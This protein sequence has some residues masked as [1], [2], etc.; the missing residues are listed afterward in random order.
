MLHCFIQMVVLEALRDL[1]LAVAPAIN[2]YSCL[3]K[4]NLPKSESSH[5][6]VKELLAKQGLVTLEFFLHGFIKSTKRF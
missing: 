6:I 4:Y 1:T 2:L 3:K 5:H